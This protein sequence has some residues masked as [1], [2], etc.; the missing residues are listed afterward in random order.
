LKFNLRSLNGEKRTTSPV[1]EAS[2]NHVLPSPVLSDAVNNDDE[3]SDIEILSDTE[4]GE[5]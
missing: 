3:T 2:N 1:F 5:E 4:G